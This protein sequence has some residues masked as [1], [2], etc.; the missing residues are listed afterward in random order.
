MKYAVILHNGMSDHINCNTIEAENINQA[1]NEVDQ[2][3]TLHD[4]ATIFPLNDL[5]RKRLRG[6]AERL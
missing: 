1:Y 2:I 3:K 4:V 5:N 6:L